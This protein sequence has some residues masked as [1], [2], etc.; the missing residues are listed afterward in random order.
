MYILPTC[1]VAAD[2]PEDGAAVAAAPR[3]ELAHLF[4][5]NTAVDSLYRLPRR[6]CSNIIE[7]IISSE[8]C[9]HQSTIKI[10]VHYHYVPLELSYA[11]YRISLRPLISHMN[12]CVS[13]MSTNPLHITCHH[14]R[15]R[16]TAGCRGTNFWWGLC[17]YRLGKKRNKKTGRNAVLRSWW[18]RNYFENPKLSVSWKISCT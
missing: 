12:M 16:S 3:E 4:L 18:S 9:C 8:I 15:L 1:Q 10:Q 2:Q 6:C 7:I 17:K 5:L 13:P 11:N 14:S